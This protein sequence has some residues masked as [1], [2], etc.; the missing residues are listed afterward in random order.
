[1]RY[2]KTIGNSDKMKVVKKSFEGE[3]P[4]GSKKVYHKFCRIATKM[5]FTPD[6][7]L[8]VKKVMVVG[9]KISGVK[10]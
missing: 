7:I 6:P 3:K 5:C 1:M 4:D 2:K 10:R 9:K 8:L